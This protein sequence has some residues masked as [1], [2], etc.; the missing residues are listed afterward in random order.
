MK[1]LQIF[2]IACICFIGNSYGQ[3]LPDPIISPFQNGSYVPGTLGV[4]DYVNP[5]VSG[6]VISDYNTWLWSN[7][8]V[9]RDGNDVNAIELIPE[10]GSIPIDVD[11]SGYV[12]N[13]VVTYASPQISALGNA[14]YI[15]FISPNY[16]TV[17]ASVGLGQLTNGR[18]LINGGSSG[19]GDLAVAPVFL[20][21]GW[22][23]VDLTAGYMFTA[24]TGSFDAGAD[25]NI[26]LGYWSHLFQASTYF[27]SANK[28]TAINLMPSYEFHSKIKDVDV[29]AGGRFLFE[30]GI[31]QTI[32]NQFEITVEGG[33]S[34]QVG[35]DTGEDVYWDTSFRDRFSTVGL[36]LGCW[37][38]ADK[39]YTQLRWSKTY[40]NRD[41]F[42]I[43]TLG[44]EL[45]Y[46][47]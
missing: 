33:H 32:A 15:F 5:G 1:R 43:N 47:P 17:N 22:D 21:W 44:L 34:W 18:D 35:E 11:I 42:K 39:F 6:W 8:F 28:N 3:V 29:K 27:Y 40:G 36:G 9:N 10:L 26:G 37:L 16:A 19:F 41:N 46:I 7:K 20:S 25:D 45:V 31:S 12:N 23:K 2:C 4:R 13:L 30:Y 38:T 24:P 14:Q